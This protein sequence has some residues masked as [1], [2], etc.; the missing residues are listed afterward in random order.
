MAQENFSRPSLEK[1]TGSSHFPWLN[2]A[3]ESASAIAI[4][5]AVHAASN[6]YQHHNVEY[7]SPIE[8]G[9]EKVDGIF[10]HTAIKVNKFSGEVK[11]IRYGWNHRSYTDMNNDGRVDTLFI[12]K[13]TFLRGS[14]DQTFI[15]EMDG[16][17]YS[18]DFQKADTD[19]NTQLY[20]FK[21]YMGIKPNSRL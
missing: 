11:V 7:E 6:L 14:I 15:R 5:T 3:W 2:F 18:D 8:R 12:G 9:V 20:R 17:R 16:L 1:E 21:D 10:Y 13:M 4:I 19:F